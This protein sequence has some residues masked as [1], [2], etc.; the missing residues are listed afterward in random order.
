MSY[1]RYKKLQR[2]GKIMKMP[3]I[4]L[5]K[6]STDYYITY[7][8]NETRLD[9]VSYN[10]YGVSEYDWL[11]LLANQ[12]IASLEFEIPNGSEIRIPYPLSTT[13]EDYNSQIDNY[14]NLYGLD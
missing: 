8:K 7:K 14:E 5:K 13:I 6:K 2:N 11:I 12:D 3:P 4:Q 1:N 10:A 9:N